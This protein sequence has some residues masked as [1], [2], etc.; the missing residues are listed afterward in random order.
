MAIQTTMG[1]RSDVHFS[2]QA[3]YWALGIIVALFIAIGFAMS[4]NNVTT[5]SDRTSVQDTRGTASDS[6][7][8]GSADSGG[9]QRSSPAG[10]AN[11]A[12]SQ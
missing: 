4:R 9:Y 2:R 6:N 1:H 12:R 8:N 11:P 5:V 7:V 10:D 3:M